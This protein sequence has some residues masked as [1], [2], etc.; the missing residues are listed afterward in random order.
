MTAEEIRGGVVTELALLLTE[1]KSEFTVEKVGSQTLSDL[2]IDSLMMLEFLMNVE[3][4]FGLPET[5][6]DL[7]DDWIKKFQTIDDVIR[8]VKDSHQSAA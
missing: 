7:D 6:D 5:E 3:R 4:H 1:D 8:M 2:G